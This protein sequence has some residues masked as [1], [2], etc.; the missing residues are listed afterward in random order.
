M[1]NIKLINLI[2]KGVFGPISL[3][4]S[5]RKVEQTFGKPEKTSSKNIPGLIW[6]FGNLEITFGVNGVASIFFSLKN[7]NS[8]YKTIYI[9][10][11]EL[12]AGMCSTKFEKFLIENGIINFKKGTEIGEGK[13]YFLPNYVNISFTNDILT[14]MSIVN[15]KEVP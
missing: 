4:D 8:L 3:N 9:E 2:N 10:D 1:Q 13:I 15:T 11:F 14:S 5:I 7:I 6:K 12:F